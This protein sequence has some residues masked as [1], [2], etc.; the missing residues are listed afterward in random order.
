V[1]TRTSATMP[2]RGGAPRGGIP[3]RGK[4]AVPNRRRFALRDARIRA[5]LG[6]IL[7]V[8]IL[9][10]LGLTTLRLVDSTQRALSAQLV[11]SLTSLSADLA[12]TTHEMQRERIL[13]AQLL[14]NEPT[15]PADY[16]RQVKVTKAATG[17]FLAHRAKVRRVPAALSTVL[18]RIG[19]QLSTVD[20]LREQVTS[21]GISPDEA[22]V[23]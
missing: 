20:T 6:A 1:S 3:S 22:V 16:G 4:A 12:D 19:A 11:A 7:V 21:Q 14:A 15:A 2:A 8:P 17:D 13:A 5:K 10:I 18:D 9:A 23:R